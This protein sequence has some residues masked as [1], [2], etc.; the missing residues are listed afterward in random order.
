MRDNKVRF[1]GCDCQAASNSE[2]IMSG[3]RTL[4]RP[5]PALTVFSVVSVGLLTL[6]A[7][8]SSGSGGGGS[9]GSGYTKPTSYIVGGNLCLSG[10]AGPNGQHMQEGMN[11]AA[12]VL[13]AAGGIGGVPVKTVYEDSQDDP[14]LGLTAA[15]KLIQVDHAVALTTC[16]S[17]VLQASIQVAERQYGGA[18]VINAG[19]Q[20]PDLI[21]LSKYLINNIVNG[22]T[23]AIAMMRYLASTGHKK[24]CIFSATDDFGSG[25][26]KAWQ[27]D[28]S[29]FGGTLACTQT[30]SY[31]QSDYRSALSVAATS[32]AD[33][34]VVY[35]YGDAIIPFMQQTKALGI[36]T[37]VYSFGGV[38]TDDLITPK[39]AATRGLIFTAPYFNLAS[40]DPVTKQFLTAYKASGDTTEPPNF[41][42]IGNYEAMMIFADAEKYIQAHHLP[43]DGD[44]LSEAVHAIKT[45]AGIGG[46]I[47]INPDGTVQRPLSLQEVEAGS[48]KV[49]NTDLPSSLPN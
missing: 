11:L 44:S 17:D 18:M 38:Q 9:S 28:F 1:R 2:E 47:T 48:F 36:N 35:T 3:T 31:T 39:G 24:V 16:G 42:V 30:I 43:N 45:F 6:A 7:C 37:P 29:K 8:G 49:L 27:T 26:L 23:E 14:Q 5:G 4:R 19:A 32:H 20:A 22:Q 13:N 40:P 21:G 25:V 15:Q 12:K 41:Y 33:A 34:F 10:P 46:N